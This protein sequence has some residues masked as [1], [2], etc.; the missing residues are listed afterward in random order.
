M[1]GLGSRGEVNQ[2]WNIIGGIFLQV[3]TIRVDVH[4]L[5]HAG[6]LIDCAS[7]AS[8]SALA[9]FRYESLHRYTV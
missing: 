1:Q 2:L 7:I 3:W 6:N 4:I 9:H 5:N 8:I